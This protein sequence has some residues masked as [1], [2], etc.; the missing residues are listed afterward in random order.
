MVTVDTGGH[1]DVFPGALVLWL[2]TPRGG[3]GYVLP[4]EAKIV[5]SQR[6]PRE[7]VT[8]EVQTRAGQAVLR[9]VQAKNLRWRTQWLASGGEVPEEP[10][11]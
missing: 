9:R 4:I 7:S 10:R 2:H 5:A 3:Y 8:I 6:R 11:G 1:D